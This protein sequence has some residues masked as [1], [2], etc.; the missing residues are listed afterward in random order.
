M[1]KQVVILLGK[2]GKIQVEANG[3]KGGTCEEATAF[4]DDLFGVEKRKH[5]ESYYENGDT[6]IDSLPN[7]YCG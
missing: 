6:L 2:D 4:L 3:F 1:S 7:G 5:K